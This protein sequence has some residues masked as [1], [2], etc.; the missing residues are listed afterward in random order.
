MSAHLFICPPVFPDGLLTGDALPHGGAPH[1]A[2][3]EAPRRSFPAQLVARRE[4]D[5]S[6]RQRRTLGREMAAVLHLSSDL[7]WEQAR[8]PLH[9]VVDT[10]SPVVVRLSPDLRWEQAR[11]PLHLVHGLGR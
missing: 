6:C 11:E 2:G 7:R 9:Q 3:D 8:E 5:G 1:L 4:K 10:P